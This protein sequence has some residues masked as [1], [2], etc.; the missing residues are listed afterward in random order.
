[1]KIQVQTDNLRLLDQALLSRC[2]GVRVGSEFCEH[3]LPSDAALEKAY[4]AVRE[5]GKPFTYVTPRLSVAGM[6]RLT[7]Q[8]AL[9]E[10]WGGATVVAND[11][12][13]LNVLPR[14]SKLTPHLGRHLV[15]VPDRSPWAEGLIHDKELTSKQYRWLVNL[16]ASTSLNYM[17]TLD[18]YRSMGVQHVDLDWAPRIFPSLNALAEGG[19]RIALLLHFVPGT[20]TRRCHMARFL[21]EESHERCSRP[22][23]RRA[24]MLKSEILKAAGL[25]LFVVGNAVFRQEEPTAEAVCDLAA[26]G[27]AEVV[28]M[29]NALTRLETATQVDQF[30]ASLGL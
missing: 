24:F 1:M 20:M 14:H 4:A 9:L 6:E 30:T 8:L 28:V 11:Y 22:C 29:M 15:R 18:L 13:T 25:R 12:G 10:N 21:G 3:L 26:R 27:V 23:Q 2:D 5:A 7:A 16:Y 19:L 17:P